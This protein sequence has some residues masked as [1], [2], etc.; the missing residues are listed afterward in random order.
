V[1]RP[2]PVRH[3]EGV[4]HFSGFELVNAFAAIGTLLGLAVPLYL[5]TCMIV[6]GVR[7]MSKR[8]VELPPARVIP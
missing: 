2:R 1:A 5:A 6:R 3:A 8:R 7:R 4:D